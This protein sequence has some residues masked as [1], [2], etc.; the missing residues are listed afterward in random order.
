MVL[1]R[2]R[3]LERFGSPLFTPDGSFD[4]TGG[5]FM[6]SRLSFT[7]AIGLVMS[8]FVAS[9][10]AMAQETGNGT[11]TDP[12]ATTQNHDFAIHGFDFRSPEFFGVWQRTD[13]PVRDGD[14]ARSWLWGPR[15]NTEV[16]EEPYLEAAGGKREVQYGDKSRM[17][18]PVPGSSAAASR[19]TA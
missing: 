10:S 16:F 9:F 14:V 13:E 5:Q 4:L 2:G 15:A 8:L 11:D 12:D 1:R 3:P 18:M 7:L 19:G 17:E 6:R